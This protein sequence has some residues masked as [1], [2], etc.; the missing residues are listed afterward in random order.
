MLMP[1]FVGL[2]RG[3]N[4]GK[5]NRVPMVEL[6]ALVEG[7]GGSD[8]ATLLNS[9]NVVFSHSGRSSGKHATAISAALHE[10]LGVSVPVVVKSAAEF[11]AVLR[12]NP[13]PPPE[14]DHSR[15]LVAFAQEAT[16]LQALLPLVALA[17]PPERLVV[18]ASA[19]YLHCPQGLLQ[20]RTGEALLGKTGRGVTTRNWATVLKLAVLLGIA[21]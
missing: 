2:L 12:D 20:S 11:A 16:A 10:R 18:G 13:M 7:L 21:S 5:G 1:R 3:V 6:R 19:A 15:F 9:G 8:V 4:V 14:E 17:Q